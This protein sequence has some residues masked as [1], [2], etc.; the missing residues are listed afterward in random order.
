M[1]PFLN[2]KVL[3]ATIHAEILAEVTEVLESAQYVLGPKVAA[4]EKAFAAYCG[5]RHTVGTNSGTSALHMALVAADIRPGDE[6]ITTPMT[7]MATTAAILYAGAMPVFVDIDPESSNMDPAKIEAAITPR[8]KAIMPVHL[9]GHMADMPRICAIAEKHGLLVIEDAAQAH[10][11]EWNGKR[12]GSWGHMACFS[13]YPGKN[14]GACGEA[15][16]VVTSDDALAERLATHRDWGQK[17]RYNHVLAGFNARMEGIQGAVLGVKLRHLE[18]WT[19]QRRH[20]A[21]MYAEKL[22]GIPGL[23]L[24]QKAPE[25]RHVYHIYAVRVADR[26]GLQVRLTEKGIGTGIHYPQAVHQLA[27]YK[28]MPFTKGSW[29]HAEQCAAEVLSLPMCPMMTDAQVLE[30]CLHIREFMAC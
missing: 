25:A 18:G 16:A 27:C 11:A 10:G 3:F 9:Y 26:L 23:L 2:L 17:G 4:F 29:P 21:A 5:V 6:V 14:L 8:T 1:V 24:P 20:I 30:V 13:F 15:G 22:T 19:E 12:A 7:F 28:D